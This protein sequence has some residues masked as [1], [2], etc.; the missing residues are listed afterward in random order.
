MTSGSEYWRKEF[1]RL[2]YLKK[3]VVSEESGIS[4]VA[5]TPNN[6]VQAPKTQKT[7]KKKKSR[8]KNG[9]KKKKKKSPV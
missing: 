8:R 1:P 6:N 4:L 9:T 5:E 3:C 2:D 7:K